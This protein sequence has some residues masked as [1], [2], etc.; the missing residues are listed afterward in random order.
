MKRVVAHNTLFS[1]VKIIMIIIILLDG[2]KS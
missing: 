2:Y 1:K